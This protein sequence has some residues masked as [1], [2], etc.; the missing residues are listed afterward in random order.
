M[1]PS[2]GA[3]RRGGEAVL[4]N[5][6]FVYVLRMYKIVA[7]SPLNGCEGALMNKRCGGVA[8][9]ILARFDGGALWLMGV[10]EV[11]E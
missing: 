3:V 11:V 6:I 1:I 2:L 10:R 9:L 5:D 8:T 7:I 4:K